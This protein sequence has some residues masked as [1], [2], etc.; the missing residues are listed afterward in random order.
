MMGHRLKRILDLYSTIWQVVLP[1]LSE[2]PI[3]SPLH[4]RLVPTT[5]A[6][7][8]ITVTILPVF[9]GFFSRPT[10]SAPPVLMQVLGWPMETTPLHHLASL[11]HL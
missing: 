9:N 7:W 11:I 10:N 6:S 3:S 2:E 4:N 1:S 5:V 8:A